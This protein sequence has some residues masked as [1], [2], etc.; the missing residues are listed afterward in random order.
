[1]AMSVH[2]SGLR[3]CIQLC[4]CL[5]GCV[6]HYRYAFEGPGLTMGGPP[7]PGRTHLVSPHRAL[8]VRQSGP[9]S[10]PAGSAD[11]HALGT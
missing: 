4:G 7:C 11:V 3:G 2:F 5:G 9:G 6:C 8:R 10:E 1:M